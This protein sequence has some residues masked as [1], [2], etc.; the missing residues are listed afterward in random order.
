MLALATREA[1]VAYR[2]LFAPPR[3]RTSKYLMTF[4]LSVSLRHD[5][6]DPVFDGVGLE[7]FKNR[8]NAFLML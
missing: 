8:V 2:Q 1:L 4:V 5:L 6:N 7:G 3:C